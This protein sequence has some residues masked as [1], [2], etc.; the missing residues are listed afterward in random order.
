MPPPWDELGIPP[1]SDPAAIRRAYAVR[2]KAVRPDA[3]PQGFARLRAAY[4]RAL[5][6]AAVPAP[7]PAPPEAVPA[8][9]PA[10]PEA[11]PAPPPAPP[12]PP[13]PHP[14]LERLRRGDVRGA[15]EWLLAARASGALGL[16][17]DLRLADRLGWAMAQDGELPV[18]A[19]LDAAAR[20]GWPEGAAAAA[21]AGALRARLDAERWLAELHRVAARRTRWLGA[22]DPIAAR[23]MLGR[24][25]PARPLGWLMA[26]DPRLRRRYGEHLVHVPVLGGRIDP[27]RVA[28]LERLLVRRLHPRVEKVLET[29]GLLLVV[30]AASWLVGEAAAALDPRLQEGVTGAL[31]LLGVPA[32]VVPA[33]RRRLERLARRLWRW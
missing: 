27:A 2:L 21:W 9:P 33:L 26:G 3:D 6:G 8:P 20:L 30:W 14:M 24:G 1:T 10:P 11:V 25:R 29:L 16:A 31:L 18:A 23:L 4:E 22:A 13:P 7:A 28:A 15:T 17:E 12:V 5:A 32:V 19:V